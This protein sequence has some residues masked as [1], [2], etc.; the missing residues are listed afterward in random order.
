RERERERERD[1][2]VHI[3]SLR[4][5]VGSSKSLFFLYLIFSFYLFEEIISKPPSNS[6]LNSR[7]RFTYHGLYNKDESLFYVMMRLVPEKS[8]E[9]K[10]I[11][12]ISGIATP[13][14][15]DLSLLRN[16]VLGCCW[17]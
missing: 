16:F 6:N 15:F 9:R 4:F 8:W 12:R 2:A 14:C 7:S 11:P 1:V 13:H 3:S 10:R 17:N 5:W